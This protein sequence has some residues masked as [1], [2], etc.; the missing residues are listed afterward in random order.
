MS[1]NH[2]QPEISLLDI[3]CNMRAVSAGWGLMDNLNKLEADL[4]RIICRLVADICVEIELSNKS[5]RNEN[6]SFDIIQLQLIRIGELRAFANLCLDYVF[7]SN[8]QANLHHQLAFLSRNAE[9][10][11][12]VLERTMVEIY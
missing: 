3:S 5:H 7:V 12:T 8:E 2:H 10:A 9:A 6:V 11:A 4:I 1:M